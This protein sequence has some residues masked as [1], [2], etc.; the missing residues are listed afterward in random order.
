M[1]RLCRQ[2]YR[3]GRWGTLA[4]IGNPRLK[5]A[6]CF[7]LIHIAMACCLIRYAQASAP[8]AGWEKD[9]LA[10]SMCGPRCLYL[11]ART[12]GKRVSLRDMVSLAGTTMERGTSVGNMVSAA[13]DLGL[14]AAVAKTDLAGLASHE[15]ACI[16]IADD[17]RHFLFLAGIDADAGV[18][19]L[20]DGLRLRTLPLESLRR[21]WNGWAILI[22]PDAPSRSQ[23]EHAQIPIHEYSVALGAFSAMLGLALVMRRRVRVRQ[24]SPPKR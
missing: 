6:S 23:H 2:E 13:R 12:C 16:L 5:R 18:L 1:P 8:P 15:G 22:S 10:R 9:A 20:I 7:F 14:G 19:S 24:G 21:R 11:A 3:G 4:F 17:E